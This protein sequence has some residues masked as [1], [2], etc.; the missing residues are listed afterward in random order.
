ME[1]PGKNFRKSVATLQKPCRILAGRARN[2]PEPAGWVTSF[3]KALHTAPACAI[4]ENIQFS[5]LC[6]HATLRTFPHARPRGLTR[7][8]Q[9]DIRVEALSA[10]AHLLGEAAEHLKAQLVDLARLDRR[11]HRAPWLMGVRAIVEAAVA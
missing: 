3:S 2:V 5:L 7:R 6:M 11:A 10:H 4:D 9:M 8:L 1:L